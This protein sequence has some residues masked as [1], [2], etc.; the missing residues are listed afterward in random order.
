[1][2][3]YAFVGTENLGVSNGNENESRAK[4]EESVNDLSFFCS[5]VDCNT[6]VLLECNAL[7]QRVFKFQ[8]GANGHSGL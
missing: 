5:V 1:M 3:C 2:I 8:Q 6:T 4:K 7:E